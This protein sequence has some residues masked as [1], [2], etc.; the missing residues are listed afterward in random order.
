MSTGPCLGRGTGLDSSSRLSVGVEWHF[1]PGWLRPRHRRRL[2]LGR[3]SSASRW[4]SSAD[5]SA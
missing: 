5:E 1:S 4:M 3:L 2:L